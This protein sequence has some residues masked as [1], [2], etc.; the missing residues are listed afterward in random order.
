MILPGLWGAP[1]KAISA[2]A[3]PMTIE[4]REVFNDYD[5]GLAFA[6][7][8]GRPVVIDF[9]GY[10]CVNC[11]KMEAYVLDDDSVKSRLKNY[12]FIELFVDDKRDGIGDRNSRIQREQFGSNAQPF[13]V[14][15]D[16]NGH[17]VGTP[18][19]FT[20]DPLEFIHWLKY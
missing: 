1:V 8:T 14:Q 20:T 2:F 13:F 11:R 7:R 10:G 3:P 9:T 18:I 12:V 4:G 19:A 15:L 5:E 6:R 17:P 16:S